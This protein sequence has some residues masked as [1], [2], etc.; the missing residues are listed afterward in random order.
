MPSIR[1]L[2]RVAVAFVAASTVALGA[3]ITW[4]NSGTD[5]NAGASWAGGTA[6]VAVDTAIFNVS[7][8]TNASAGALPS[9]T[10]TTTL[11]QLRFS[12]NTANGYT[13]GAAA[14][15]SLTL[16]SAGSG[17]AVGT[18]A[19][20]V[21]VI[22]TGS[23]VIA[24][25]IIL[26][27]AAGGTQAFTQTGNGT[28]LITGNVTESAAGT[29]L[30]L[31]GPASGY[32]R[33]SGTTTVTGGVDVTAGRVDFTGPNAMSGGVNLS[34]NSSLLLS[35][36][37]ATVGS[38]NN[39]I[40]NVSGTNYVYLTTANTLLANPIIIGEN[41]KL[42]IYSG[43]PGNVTNPTYAT[44][45]I[46][47]NAG[48]VLQTDKGSGSGYTYLGNTGASPLIFG[49]NSGT[50]TAVLLHGYQSGDRTHF[51]GLQ[52]ST[53]IG[54]GPRITSSST[55]GGNILDFRVTV[56]SGTN[57][58]FNGSIQDNVLAVTKF[59]KYGDG[60]QALGGNNAYTGT[61]SITAGAL[62]FNGAGALPGGTGTTGGTSNLTLAGGVA[63]LGY[64]DFLRGTGT[65]AA[66]VL[67]STGGGFAAYGA[68]RIVNLGGAGATLTWGTNSFM[69]T[70]S[71]TFVLGAGDAT[72]AVDF[73]NPVV[74]LA[75]VATVTRAI[76]VNRG[77]GATDAILA[78]DLSQTSGTAAVAKTGGGV[79][80]LTGNNSFLGRLQIGDGAVQVAAINNSG[81][82]PLGANTTTDLG[83]GATSGTLRWVG[84]ADTT[85]TRT[86]NLSGTAGGGGAID[87]SG[88][89]ALTIGSVTAIATGAKTLTFTGTSTALNT[90]AAVIP[91]ASG[92]AVSVAKDGPGLW[93]LAATGSYSGGFALKNG[94]VRVGID[95]GSSGQSGA[96]GTGGAPV[97][98]DTAAGAAGTATL[99]AEAG[100]EIRGGVT[101]SAAG[102][103]ST[104]AVL[105][106]GI[107]SSGTATYLANTD[108]KLGRDVTLVATGG[109]VVKFES[110]WW[111]AA[112]TG[113]PAVNVTIGAADY[114]GI[115]RLSKTGTLA[116]TGAVAVRYGTAL[117]PSTST[118]LDGAG[119]L[120]ID[121]G[122][123]LGG[124]GT[125]AA[126]LG[127]AGLV[128]P[129]NSPG[130]LS[131]EAFDPTGGLDVAFEFTGLTPTYGGTANVND[132]LRLTG[133][134]PFV[135][136]SLSAANVVSLY[137]P[138]NAASGG[139]FTGGFFTDLS[140]SSFS[141]F[142]SSVTSGSYVAY[143]E[144]AGG[145]IFYGDKEY[146]LLTNQVTVGT[147]TVSGTTSFAPGGS[148]V[149]GQVTTFTVVVPEPA[150]VALA[151]IGVALAG[152]AV[153]RQRR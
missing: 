58:S 79:L 44:G 35:T 18:G 150:T 53:V 47:I 52:T 130:I 67:I 138:A 30:S 108:F 57:Y 40:T 65:T 29:K 109:G 21:S 103:G 111:D 60:T 76:R 101:V 147:T 115:V 132:I 93:R 94:T 14:G 107:N 140:S 152:Y 10:T 82:G 75:S 127:G 83:A 24:A 25:P 69:T 126:P 68:D 80:S 98:G 70:T 12:V 8:T 59:T 71:G 20:I 87:A 119:T 131:A 55:A 49:D 39:V 31:S 118:T 50:A 96:F 135:S 100:V 148:A 97:V 106:G 142:L 22:S 136:G 19:A 95:A 113:T 74:L 151:V 89:G 38:A 120:T 122:A 102:A 34:G 105:I 37:T 145:G 26:G 48:G 85:V 77:S 6:P 137:L 51:G 54:D 92:A 90:V 11:Q 66:D 86:F 33:L 64:G 16:T 42:L 56:A 9:I 62:R 153:R 114:Q 141:T 124:I 123:T 144:N 15:Q 23:N 4:N 73:R 17:T 43:P 149:D 2:A 110:N 112:G 61:T 41:S 1:G 5:F 63:G 28:L 146:S 46:T 139:T 116:T 121:Q 3:S 36:T 7:G 84:G 81:N 99:L 13:L 78:G 117:I 32:L 27:V 143:Y 88:T 104:Q 133:A 128:A 129:G 45:T 134:S 125:V 91:D 72:A